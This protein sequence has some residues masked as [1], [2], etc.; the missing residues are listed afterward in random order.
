MKKAITLCSL[1][2]LLCSCAGVHVQ[3]PE[4]N[5]VKKVAILSVSASEDIKKLEDEEESGSLKDALVGVATSAAEDNVKQLSKGREKIITHGADALAETLAGLDGWTVVSAEEVTGNADVQKFFDP[6]G[7]EGVMSK[8]A[9]LVPVNG[10]RYMTPQGMHE[11]PYETVVSGETALFG[12]KTDDQEVRE[13]AGKLC[14]SLNVDAVAVAEYYFFYEDG[15][16]TLANTAKPVVMV[17]VVLID[18]KGNKLLFTDHGWTQVKG[19]GSV[20]LVDKYVDLQSDTSVDAY[21]NTIDK[22]MA[23]FKKAAKKKL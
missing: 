13:K 9:R 8:I 22:A 4:V 5:D 23:E 17:D 7:A 3:K 20:M 14:E 12:A 10:W 2:L 15:L 16:L 18:K 19:N 11:L 6:T 1:A 21:V